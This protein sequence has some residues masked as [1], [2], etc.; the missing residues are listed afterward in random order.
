MKAFENMKTFIF[1]AALIA[2][3]GILVAACTRTDRETAQ[4]GQGRSNAAIRKPNVPDWH[5][6]ATIYEV[7]LRHF[8]P[9]GTFKSFHRHLPRLKEMGVDILWFMPVTP[10]SIKN[11]KGR[12]G[13]PYAVADYKAVN[14]DYGTMNDFKEMV[15]AIHR[16]G[17]YC[18]IDWVPNHTGWDNPW[19]KSHPEWFTQDAEGNI[20]DPVNPETGTSWGWTDVADLNYDVPEMRLAM[21][22]AMRFWVEENGVDGFRVDV[23]HNVPV[24]FWTRCT[25]TLYRIEPLFMLAESEVPALRN[26]GA[27]VM[28]YGWEMHHVFN[29]IAKTQGAVEGHKS[30]V[31]GNVVEDREK[32]DSKSMSALDIDRVL[33]KNRKRYEQGYQMYFTSNHDENSWAGTEMQRM[34]EGHR[35]FAVLAATFDGMPLVYTGQEAALDR[36]LKFFDRD[37]ID[38]GDY[39]Y[40]TFY[41]TLFDLKHRN[42]ALWNGKH[43]GE[44]VKIPT[45]NDPHI[46]AFTRKKGD[47]Q[48][49]VIVNLS[50]TAQKGKLSGNGY[51]GEYLNVFE[52]RKEAISEG[53][54]IELAP[55]AYLILS[56]R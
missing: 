49:L 20:L 22:D 44:L 53:Q 56:N 21:I 46:Y 25:D 47:D 15:N 1:L 28:D 48:V 12:L 9:E 17:M 5:R 55:W 54:E 36:Q 27:F 23:A 4:D 16:A 3:L 52:N 14:P 24:D 2:G 33:E 30:L 11:R 40:A 10:V 6:N 39:T 13:S 31:R 43:G 41:K 35:A 29:G 42:E 51:A 26:T 8:T 32:E 19:I 50:G 45:G 37:V 38:W 34:G 18:I 7:N